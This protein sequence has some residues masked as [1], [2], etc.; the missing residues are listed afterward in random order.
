MPVLPLV[1]SRTILSGVSSPLFS[2]ASIIIQGWSVFDRTSRIHAFQFSV[3]FSGSRRTHSLQRD[4][5]GIADKIKKIH[6]ADSQGKDNYRLRQE[7]RQDYAFSQKTGKEKSLSLCCSGLVRTGKRLQIASNSSQQLMPGLLIRNQGLHQS[8]I[9]GC[10]IPLSLIQADQTR[11][12]L[13]HIHFLPAYGSLPPAQP[14]P[15]ADEPVL[16]PRQPG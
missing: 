11:L 16:G 14:S 1:A 12:S 10:Q 8:A 5:R 9:G 15:A 7:K 4:K 6:Q 13:P 3:D 2:P